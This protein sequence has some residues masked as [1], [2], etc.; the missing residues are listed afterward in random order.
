MPCF[1]RRSTL[2]AVAAAIAF[3]MLAP[4]ASAKPSATPLDVAAPVSLGDRCRCWLRRKMV[5]EVDMSCYG[6][7]LEEHWDRADAAKPVV[8]VIH[9]YNSS[10]EKIHAVVA[11]VHDAGFPCGTFAY[12]NDYAISASAQL[13]S[14]ELRRFARVHPERRVV[15][16]C[17]SMGGIVARACVEDTLYD[18]GNVD[19]LILI[20]PPN[21]GTAIAHFAI[22]T[23]LWEHWLSRPDGGP[24]QRVHDS[25]V[26]GLGEAANDLCPDSTFLAELNTRPRNPQI[27]YSII[28]GTG[29]RMSEAEMNWIRESVVRKL[30]K[31]PGAKDGA[32]RLDAMLSDLDELVEGKGDGVVAVARG[33]LDGVS[34]TVV[35]PF[36]HL[37]VTGEPNTAAVRDV[38]A[39]VLERIN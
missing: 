22:G 3:G 1:P 16:V 14:S 29:A 27:H 37:S 12:P 23:D 32:E 11:A 7:V 15:L 26:D 31:L 20:A 19:R 5:S 28:L 10:P 39:T 38:Q 25:V 36:G 30:T 21:R 33:R 34:D 13:L 4:A 6:L 9:G 18:P 17:H 8:V 2:F 24:W 35:L